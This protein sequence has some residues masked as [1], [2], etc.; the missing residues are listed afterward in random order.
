MGELRSRADVEERSANS[1]A[2]PHISLSTSSA[3]FHHYQYTGD[4]ESCHSMLIAVPQVGEDG[5]AYT[6]QPCYPSAI[7][8]L[9]LTR[10]WRR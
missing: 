3:N 1:R 10:R 9:G 7:K 2:A 4:W 8:K 5:R 6:I